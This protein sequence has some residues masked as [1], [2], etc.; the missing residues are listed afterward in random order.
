MCLRP[1]SIPHFFGE[2]PF[3]ALPGGGTGLVPY[4]A[5]AKGAGD[6]NEAVILKGAPRLHRGR[7]PDEKEDDR[8]AD[9]AA[10]VALS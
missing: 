2:I 9:C 4:L 6:V 10:S 5:D 8:G 7:T 3:S 1:A